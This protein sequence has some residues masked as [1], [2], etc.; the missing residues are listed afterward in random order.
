M[1]I[2]VDKPS[3]M[4]SHDVVRLI[5]NISGVKKVGHGG[6]LDPMASGVLIIGIGRHATKELHKSLTNDKQYLATI[7]MDG[8]SNTD[9]ADGKI[10]EIN[11]S[12]SPNLYDI[13][14]V[15]KRFVGLIEQTPPIYSAIKISGKP[16]YHYARQGKQVEM[17]SREVMINKIVIEE[18]EWP[19]LR[20]IISTGS[21]VYIRALAR[22]IGEALNVGGYL[23]ELIRTKVG[24]YLLNDALGLNEIEDYIKNNLELI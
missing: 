3:G 15:L 10:E 18:Y 4:T 20:L 2:A 8:I 9:D 13:K 7:R 16:A 22:D 14:K 11:I 5:R 17:K 24:K 12:I 1:T 21:G 23:I 6:T 19:Y